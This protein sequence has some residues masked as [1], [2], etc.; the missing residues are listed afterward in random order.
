MQIWQKAVEEKSGYEVD[1][2]I[3]RRDNGIGFDMKLSGKLFGYFE[4]LH[5]A[6]E[7][8]GIGIGLAIV[9]NIIWKHGGRVWAEGKP[10]DG[11]TFFFTLPEKNGYYKKAT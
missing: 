9:K 6:T 4:R 3:R 8:S 11:A 10:D 5:A 2:R 7:V 1:Y